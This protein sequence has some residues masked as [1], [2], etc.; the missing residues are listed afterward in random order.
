MPTYQRPEDS[1]ETKK[2]EAKKQK[3]DDRQAKEDKEAT[4]ELESKKQKDR[5]RQGD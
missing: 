3:E 2:L 4:E 5:N 1:Y